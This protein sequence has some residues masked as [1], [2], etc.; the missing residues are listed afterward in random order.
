MEVWLLKG[1]SAEA[2]HHAAFC[3]EATV[4]MAVIEAFHR[5]IW[6]N[7]NERCLYEN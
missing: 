4:S 5:E 3:E 6:G 7:E 1:R 2:C